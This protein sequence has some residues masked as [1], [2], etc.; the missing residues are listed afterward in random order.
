MAIFV[1]ESQVTELLD[2]PTAIQAVEEVMKL[3][4]EGKAV[5]HPRQRVR[6]QGVI[7]H[8]MAATVPEWGVTGFKV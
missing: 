6:R 5:N 3:H 7:L 8:W 2:M 4:G 1:T